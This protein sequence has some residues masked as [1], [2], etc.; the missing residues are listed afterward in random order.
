VKTTPQPAD[1]DDQP[2]AFSISEAAH[3]L[4]VSERRIYRENRFRE[5][6]ARSQRTEN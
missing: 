1:T 3:A 2:L 5:V 6:S 4:G